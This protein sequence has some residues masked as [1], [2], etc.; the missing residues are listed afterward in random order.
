MYVWYT[1]LVQKGNKDIKVV[2]VTSG[3]VRS[4]ETSKIH[5]KKAATFKRGTEKARQTPKQ[6]KH[7]KACQHFAFFA[8]EALCHSDSVV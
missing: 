8:Q 4:F 5:W 1:V 6:E 3:L 2:H 7:S